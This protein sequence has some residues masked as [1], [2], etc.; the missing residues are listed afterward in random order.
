MKEVV[1]YRQDS[2]ALCGLIAGY[3]HHP[4]VAGATVLSLG[5]QN[6]TSRGTSRRTAQRDRAFNKPLLV[7]EQQDADWNQN[8]VRCG[9]RNF[10]RA[11][12]NQPVKRQPAPLS[13]SAWD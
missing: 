6:A 12:R 11:D 2:N 9:A 1:R 4:N 3:I 5:C 13:N 8:V 10:P 7:F